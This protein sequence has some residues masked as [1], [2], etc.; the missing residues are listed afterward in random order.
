MRLLVTG[1]R[2]YCDATT[3]ARV[4]NEK[5]PDV[6][7]VGDADG[8]DK[9]ARNWAARHGVPLMVFPAHWNFYGKSAGPQR[10]ETMITYG[11]PD[12]AV[13]FPGGPGTADM[14]RR[15]KNYGIPITTISDD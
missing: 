5:D 7:I 14:V 11:S 3:V 10:N 9:L 6:V 13:A 2:D 1:G 15:C 8:A 12:E 4:L